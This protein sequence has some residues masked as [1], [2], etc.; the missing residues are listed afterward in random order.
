MCISDVAIN[1]C[2]LGRAAFFVASYTASIS[3][4]LA[5][6]SPHILEFF[7]SD[8][9][10]CT[11]SKSPDDDAG[12]PAS[13]TSTPSLSSCSA[14]RI[15]SSVVILKPGH[16]SPSLKVVSKNINL[17]IIYSNL[18]LLLISFCCF[19]FTFYQFIAG[20]KQTKS[21]IYT[22]HHK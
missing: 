20:K 6:E 13:I 15:F 7:T 21:N 2:I 14:R 5:R 17:R 8:D 4:L 3:F 16:C 12:K 10:F 18:I 1:V 22:N 19:L 11:A 9:I